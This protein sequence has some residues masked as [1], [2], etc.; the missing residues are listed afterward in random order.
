[1]DAVQQDISQIRDTMV[2][3]RKEMQESLVANQKNMQ[4]YSM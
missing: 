4:A 1:M 2:I 3:T